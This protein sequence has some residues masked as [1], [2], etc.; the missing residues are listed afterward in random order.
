MMPGEISARLMVERSDLAS[1]TA[2]ALTLAA[3]L[4]AF[5][6]PAALSVKPYW[7]IPAY[8]EVAV[9]LRGAQGVDTLRRIADALAP[10]WH[11]L[12]ENAVWDH[13]QHG[14]FKVASLAP[15]ARWAELIA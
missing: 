15:S 10:D 14:G 4:A 8:F 12:S 11:W 6:E 13:R 9:T 5:G 7:K 3:A 2:D 1:A